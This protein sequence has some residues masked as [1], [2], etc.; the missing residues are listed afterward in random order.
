MSSLVAYGNMIR[1]DPTLG[2]LS[3]YFFVL[4]TNVK[5]VNIIIHSGCSLAWIFMKE[6]V[7][8]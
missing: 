1:C 7:K 2:N 8:G 3:N 5:F 6:R 4:C